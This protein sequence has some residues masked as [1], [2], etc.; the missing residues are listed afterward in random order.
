M[1][2]RIQSFGTGVLSNR[3]MRW[4]LSLMYDSIFGTC[5]FRWR[6]MSWEIFSVGPPH[7]LTMGLTAMGF[8]CIFLR[9]Y[10]C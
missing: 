9:K 10:S 8:L 6:S 5:G 1:V 4:P 2:T 3:D 7:P